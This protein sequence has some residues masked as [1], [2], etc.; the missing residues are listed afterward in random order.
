MLIMLSSRMPLKQLWC[1][2]EHPNLSGGAARGLGLVLWEQG[3]ACQQRRGR[4][5]PL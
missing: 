5:V 2:K 1:F 3:T 4:K